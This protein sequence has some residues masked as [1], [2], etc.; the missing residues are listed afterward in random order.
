MKN[1]ENAKNKFCKFY[2]E[3]IKNV[4][5]TTIRQKLVHSAINCCISNH[6]DMEQQHRCFQYLGMD[7]IPSID[8]DKNITDEGMVDYQKINKCLNKKHNLGRLAYNACCDK[9]FARDDPDNHKCKKQLENIN[10][11]MHCLYIPQKNGPYVKICRNNRIGNFMVCVDNVC[12]KN[13][14]TEICSKYPKVGLC[15]NKTVDE[16]FDVI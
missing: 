13:T 8:N 11:R 14:K 5:D 16:V 15:Y 1:N 2:I 10:A 4:V 9:Q 12:R 3:E 7:S 6:V